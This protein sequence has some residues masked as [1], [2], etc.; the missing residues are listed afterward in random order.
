MRLLQERADEQCDN[1]VRSLATSIQGDLCQMRAILASFKFYRVRID[2]GTITDAGDQPHV[3][4]VHESEP[5]GL[6]HVSVAE[7]GAAM[8]GEEG[9]RHD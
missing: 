9:P 5:T 7:P 1:T 8:T 3:A 2:E 4:R 6:A